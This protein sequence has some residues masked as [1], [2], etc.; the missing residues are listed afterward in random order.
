MHILRKG[1]FPHHAYSGNVGFIPLKWIVGRIFLKLTALA[2]Y[3]C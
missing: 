2:G 3:T 1:D